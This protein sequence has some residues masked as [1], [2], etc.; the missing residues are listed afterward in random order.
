MAD[1]TVDTYF[2]SVNNDGI[3]QFSDNTHL[4]HI[5]K[6]QTVVA[7][8]DDGQVYGV[9][10]PDGVIGVSYAT[11]DST[12]YIS[13]IT[14][15]NGRQVQY[16]SS[17]TDRPINIFYWSQ[18]YFPPMEHGAGI[19]LRDAKGNIVFNN[20]GFLGSF[21]DSFYSYVSTTQGTIDVPDAPHKYFKGHNPAY[22]E[23]MDWLKEGYHIYGEQ[24]PKEVEGTSSHVT[25]LPGFANLYLA[26]SAYVFGVYQ[27]FSISVTHSGKK[28]KHTHV[29]HANIG[30]H[31]GKMD[32]PDLDLHGNR[33]TMM[34]AVYDAGIDT[35]GAE[36]WSYSGSDILKWLVY[37]RRRIVSRETVEDAIWGRF[38]PEYGF[39]PAREVGLSDETQIDCS[40]SWYT[41]VNPSCSIMCPLTIWLP[42]LIADVAEKDTCYTFGYAFRR[43]E[44]GN[45]IKMETKMSQLTFTTLAGAGSL[46]Q[47]NRIVLSYTRDGVKE[48][49]DGV[50]DPDY[51]EKFNAWIDRAEAWQSEPEHSGYYT[52][53]A[54]HRVWHEGQS[55]ETVE[56][57]PSRWKKEP[58]RV[59]KEYAACMTDGVSCDLSLVY[60]V[61]TF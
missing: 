31:F 2:E 19:E 15:Y 4:L 35:R 59:Q 34:D 24:P 56:A 53:D 1:K 25:T 5:V 50:E 60:I 28:G 22:D 51:Q 55:Y 21:K 43:T 52:G 46:E 42:A 16:V 33:K 13:P 58:T 17:S 37:P 30:Y 54:H 26:L 12:L 38:N 18:D 57:P 40:N 44:H 36:Y 6:Q 10:F 49:D 23:Y 32:T 61:D 45:E 8:A 27:V 7:C 20:T 9:A 47:L 39:Y 3:F 41:T 48:L 14:E 29:H 11:T